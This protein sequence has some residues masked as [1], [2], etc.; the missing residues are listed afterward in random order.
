MC[1]RSNHMRLTWKDNLQIT[2][3]FT[4]PIPMTEPTGKWLPDFKKGE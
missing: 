2:E 3:S 1:P 4:G